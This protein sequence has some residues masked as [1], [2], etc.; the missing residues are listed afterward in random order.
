MSIIFSGYNQ[1]RIGPA[2]RRSSLLD[3][4]RQ[5]QQA[6]SNL[7]AN[8]RALGDALAARDLDQDTLARRRRVLGE[9]HPETLLSADNLAADL[10]AMQALN[11]DT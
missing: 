11:D 6:R 8:L 1:S 4:Y 10:S 7:A 5:L 3:V 2:S 9:D